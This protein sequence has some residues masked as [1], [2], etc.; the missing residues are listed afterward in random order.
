MLFGTFMNRTPRLRKVAIGA[1]LGFSLLRRI[2][3]IFNYAAFEVFIRI[4]LN[5]ARNDAFTFI[6]AES[7]LNIII[8]R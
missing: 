4:R 1:E 6:I 2:P 5:Q 7:S 8:L 3:K